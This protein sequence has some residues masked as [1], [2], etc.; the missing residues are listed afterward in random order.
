M[1]LKNSDPVAVSAYFRYSYKLKCDELNLFDFV[2]CWCNF[3]AGDEKAKSVF[4]H[5]WK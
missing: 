3:V 5:D 4:N 2:F 1:F